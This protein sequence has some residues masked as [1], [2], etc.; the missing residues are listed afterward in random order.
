MDAERT[1]PTAWRFDHFTLDLTRGVLLT[2]GGPEIALRPKSMA[3]LRLL[4]ENA[5][6][7]LDRDAIMTAV[8]PDV[9]VS[10]ESIT[11]CVRDVRKALGDEAQA[12]V[13]TVPKRGYLLA[14]QV[15]LAKAA[16]AAPRVTRR[17]AAIVAAG[18]VDRAHL[19][20]A[21][22]AGTLERLAAHHDEFV[23]P[24]VT[25]H[26]GRVAKLSS[27]GALCEFASVVDAVGCAVAIQRGMPERESAFPEAERIRFRVGVHLGDIGYCAHGDIHGDCVDIAMGL[28]ALSPAGGIAVSASVHDLLIGNLAELCFSDLGAWL[29]QAGE[30]PL[31]VLTIE[32]PLFTEYGGRSSQK[33][34]GSEHQIQRSKLSAGVDPSRLSEKFDDLSRLLD[35]LLIRLDDAVAQQGE[36][37]NRLAASEARYEDLVNAQG[38]F[39]ARM[40]P[41]MRLSFVS[42]AYCRFYRRNR[43]EL[44]CRSF[45]ELTFTA[46]E[47]CKRHTTHLSALTPEHPIHAAKLRCRLPDGGIRWVEWTDTA[48][49]DGEGRLVEIQSIGRDITERRAGGLAQNETQMEVLMLPCGRVTFVNEAFCRHVRKPRR[50]LLSE[51]FNGLDLMAPE[52]RPHFEEHLRKLT[53][54]RPVAAMEARAILSDGSERREYWVDRGVF[55]PGGRLVA[56]QSA[57][58]DVTDGLAVSAS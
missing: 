20:Q 29:P 35:A 21:D 24:L 7:L 8:W 36:V 14:A 2:D 58:R 47:E 34:L 57:G 44:L 3:L 6:R 54:E 26:R 1:P 52:D 19:M 13:R 55:D 30:R 4:V 9:M 32:P 48:L 46:L 50:F 43:E 38:G 17:L 15:T 28:E 53:P 41:D 33:L 27:D 37:L 49:F 51:A 31:R 25:R 11:Q 5:G 45:N 40:T 23:K 42:D 22:E 10:D 16:L 12:L 39:M 56:L 18:V